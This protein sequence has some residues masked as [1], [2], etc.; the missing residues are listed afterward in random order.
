MKILHEAEARE[1]DSNSIISVQNLY[2]R[3]LRNALMAAS[4][5]T[6][7]KNYFAVINYSTEHEAVQR[8]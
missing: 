2:I 3:I 8:I 5:I 4:G 1:T 7:F 6:E